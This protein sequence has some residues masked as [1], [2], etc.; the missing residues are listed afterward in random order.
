MQVAD[1]AY[2]CGPAR[3]LMGDRERV[4]SGDRPGGDQVGGSSLGV[5]IGEFRGDWRR[6]E[7]LVRRRGG[8]VVAETLR[9]VAMLVRLLADD[10]SGFCGASLNAELPSPDSSVLPHPSTLK[11]ASQMRMFHMC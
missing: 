10:E 4:G 11:D 1:A 7:G 3:V 6:R 8:G 9:G 5:V 2:C